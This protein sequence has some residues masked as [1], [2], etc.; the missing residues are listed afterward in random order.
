M[1]NSKPL[2]HILSLLLLLFLHKSS[3]QPPLYTIEPDEPEPEVEVEI[4]VE[5]PVPVVTDD[6][7]PQAVINEMGSR[8][9]RYHHFLWHNIRDNW[10]RFNSD[11]QQQI[12]DL[13]WEPPRPAR[14]FEGLNIVALTDNDS[15]QDFLYMHRQMIDRVKQIIQESGSSFELT[16]WQ[17]VPA[18]GDVDYPSDP[19]DIPGNSSV[20]ATINLTKTDEF[21][22]D[23]IVPMEETFIDEDTLRNMT[24]GQ[25]GSRLENTIH[26]WMHLRFSTASPVGYR[27]TT[28][29][30]FPLIDARW[31]DLAYNWLGDT[32]S[33]HVNPIFWKLHGWVDDRIEDWRRVNGIDEI[34]WTATWV[35]GPM[36]NLMELLQIPEMMEAAG[37]SQQMQQQDMEENGESFSQE[38]QINTV[39]NVGSSAPETGGSTHNDMV[40]M[41]PN[42]SILGS[43]SCSFADDIQVDF[44][45]NGKVVGVG[46]SEPEPE[47]EPGVF[48]TTWSW[49][50]KM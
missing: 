18:P 26:N 33:S 45:V 29:E 21:Y 19:Y 13:E 38:I 23:Q 1:T 32:Y 4:E 37:G 31:D 10:N 25:L 3:S 47:R 14:A 6:G 16:G 43:P 49:K 22:N 7:F 40:V 9:M 27:P 39:S 34:Q 5:V 44:G 17:T 20:V 48:S 36:E 42:E 46:V 30:A 50:K 35:G 28:T 15:G 12:R 8:Q 11:I 24:L 41:T 2:F